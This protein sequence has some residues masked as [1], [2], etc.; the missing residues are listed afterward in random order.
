LCLGFVVVFS[1]FCFSKIAFKQLVRSF[2]FV[3]WLV[4][5]DYCTLGDVE[6]VLR[7][8]LAES[9]DA[10]V[11][12]CISTSSGLVDGFLKVKGLVVPV[13]VPVLVVEAAAWF[14]AWEFRRISDPVGA[15]AF[16]SEAKRLL[17]LYA[18]A[19]SEQYVGSV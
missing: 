10:L 18:E 1:L 5:L 2:V 16:W 7:E 17:D 6:G 12:R 14:A 8:T 9:L 4:C 3:D 15:E 11:A 13:V 19:E